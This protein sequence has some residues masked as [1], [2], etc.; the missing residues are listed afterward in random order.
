MSRCDDCKH[1][2][3]TTFGLLPAGIWGDCHQI[4]PDGSNGSVAVSVGKFGDD[5]VALRTAPGF[6]CVLFEWRDKETER[7][8]ARA[9]QQLT[10]RNIR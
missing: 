2:K 5:F 6:G 7:V 8:V 9:A 10:P 1:W 4:E 3:E